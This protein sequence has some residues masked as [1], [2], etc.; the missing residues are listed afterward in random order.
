[1]PGAVRSHPLTPGTTE[2]STTHATMLQGL[3]SLPD[4]SLFASVP[5][6]CNALMI[7]DRFMVEIQKVDDRSMIDNTIDSRRIRDRFDIDL[8]RLIVDS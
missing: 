6:R 8:R 1:M 3:D 4:Y 7:H 2:M 5:C